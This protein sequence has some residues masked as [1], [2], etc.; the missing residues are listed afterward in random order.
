MMTA[1]VKQRIVP[2]LLLIMGLLLAACDS[3]SSGGGAPSSF[4]NKDTSTLA[5]YAQGIAVNGDQIDACNGVI[6]VSDMVLLHPAV[7]RMVLVQPDQEVQ[8][9][10]A[11]EVIEAEQEQANKITI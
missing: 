10:P 9:T 2:T 1:M 5:L 11:P 3:N 6:Y 8:F 7:E 4:M